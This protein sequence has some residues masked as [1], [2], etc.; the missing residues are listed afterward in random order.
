MQILRLRK[1]SILALTLLCL[2]ELVQAG[3]VTT[4]S[5]ASTSNAIGKFSNLWSRNDMPVAA[6]QAARSW[7]WGTQP[8]KVDFEP[9]LEAPGGSRQVAYWDKSRMEINNP[10]TDPTSP[11]Y[12]TNGLLVKELVSGQIQTGDNRYSASSPAT[13]PVAGDPAQVNPAAPTYATFTIFASL[14]NDHR[15]TQNIGNPVN[16]WIDNR[17]NLRVDSLLEGYKVVNSYY[18]PLVGHNIPDVFINYFNSR[19]V[20]YKDGYYSYDR[21]FDWVFAAG[22]P[23]TEPYWITTKIAGKEQNVLVQLFQR[24]VLTY[25]PANSPEWRVEMGNVGQH[26]YTWRYGSMPSAAIQ[27]TKTASFVRFADNWQG[28]KLLEIGNGAIQ[29][30]V[31]F[32]NEG[33]AISTSL[34]NLLTGQEYLSSSGAEFRITLSHELAGEPDNNVVLDSGMFRATAFELPVQGITGSVARV[35]LEGEFQGAFVKV[36][37]YYQALSAENFIRKWIEV[38]PFEAPD[39]VIKQVILEDWQAIPTLEPI[40]PAQRFAQ[41]FGS[42]EPNYDASIVKK[43]V[44]LDSLS[45]RYF[46]ANESNAIAALHNQKEGLYFF[47]ESL[48]GDELFTNKGNLKIGNTDFVE[49]AKGFRSGSSVLGAWRGNLELGFKRYNEYIYNQYA[50]VKGKRDPVWFSTWY[51]YEQEINEKLLLDVIDQMQLVGFYDM[52]HID[53]GWQLGAPLQVNPERFP[54]GLDPIVAKLKAN[55]KTLGLW[56]NPFSRSYEAQEGYNEFAAQHPKWVDK[57]DPKQ[58]FCPLSGAG[59]YIHARMLE[60]A[61]NYPLEEIY[62][63]GRDWYISGCQSSESRW[64]TPDEEHHEMIKYYASLL[65]ELRTIRPD[66]RVALWSAPANVHWLSVVDQVQLSD[67]DTP[68]ILEGE[69]AR[70]QQIFQATYEYPYSSIWGDWYGVNY[71]RTLNQGLGQPLNILKYATISVIGNGATQAGGSL[72]L[73]KVPKEY[74][75]FL[76]ELFNWRKQFAEYFT[77]YQHVLN[78]PDGVNIDGAAHILN[79]RGFIILFNPSP[80]SGQVDLPLSEP[81][82]ELNAATAYTLND[83]TE[84][85]E[86]I[87]MG[88]VKPGDTYRLTIPGYG[89]RIIGVNL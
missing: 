80:N 75:S 72:D 86:P 62:W 15:A 87:Q 31:L 40:A 56:I 4:I 25:N 43:Q 89:Y 17:A 12:L 85:T 71:R 7:L 65:S 88:K 81:S 46:V 16:Q 66:L 67:L 13:A 51:P 84:L 57:Q 44:N 14:N 10:N 5:Y 54:N 41:T 59:D 8:I 64:R 36:W 70:R 68:P 18:E 23:I 11:W 60:I 48:F 33:G 30:E 28:D 38:A 73:T 32:G 39:W 45:E 2:V 55:N 42:A 52:L 19:G 37:L 47:D 24:R 27:G 69:L 3:D 61:R 78:F 9:Y 35:Q 79:G 6:G 77:V 21:L 76:K 22:L 26:Y 49:P 83:W 50:V 20:V 63:D 74:L 1:I 58:R 34:Q 82:L 29:R 53:A